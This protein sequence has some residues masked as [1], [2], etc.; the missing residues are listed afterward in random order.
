MN[1]VAN[2]P[3]PPSE[4]ELPCGAR[5]FFFWKWK[6]RFSIGD[7]IPRIRRNPRRKSPGAP[8]VSE[9]AWNPPRAVPRL[10]RR[11]RPSP[12]AMA[13]RIMAARMAA[14]AVMHGFATPERFGSL[15]RKAKKVHKETTW[16]CD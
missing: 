16:R 2:P 12:V 7:P 8:P 1:L 13:A 5:C 6:W 9:C 10:R 14:R 4:T 11:G 15:S 3:T